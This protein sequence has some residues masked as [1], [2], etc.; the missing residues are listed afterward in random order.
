MSKSLNS[1]STPL[2]PYANTQSSR[3]FLYVV[4]CT[5]SLTAIN[6]G[7]VI[8]NINV[9][10]N[11]FN[12]CKEFLP[13]N[14]SPSGLQGCFL[15][16]TSWWGL[17][18]AGVP[19]GG[20][21][22]S[23][24]GG[25]IVRSFGLKRTILLMNIPMTLGFLLM[26]FASNLGMLV[27]GRMLQ[28]FVCGLSGVAVP[29]YISAVTPAKLSGIFINFFQLFL[30]F[31]ILV[32]EVFSYSADLGRY[33]WRWRYGFGAGLIVCASQV[34]SAVL[35]N[36]PETPNELERRD[37]MQKASALRQRLGFEASEAANLKDSAS[38][39]HVPKPDLAETDTF[40]DSLW[41]LL[42]FKISKANKSMALGLLLHAGQQICGVNA[43]FFYSSLIFAGGKEQNSSFNDPPTLNPISLAAVNVIMTF[44]AIWLLNRSGRR[45]VVLVSAAA[46]FGVFDSL[47]GLH[48]ESSQTL[49][50]SPSRLCSLLLCGIRTSSVDDDAGN[51]SSQM[52]AY[53]GR[54][55]NL[56]QCKLD[57][58]H[59][60]YWCFPLRCSPAQ[61]S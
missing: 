27:V 20:W 47:G 35:G 5:A 56:C 34:V 18:G 7:Y 16:S 29:S 19:L 57:R 55:F 41:N 10:G 15:V 31:G 58:Q 1:S 17:V 42:R 8:A 3:L 26:A 6:F 38:D 51:L 59:P 46:S 52:A 49:G 30:V 9:A 54:H 36:L 11:V 4:V 12:N 43:V 14:S 44:V 13:K 37:L 53:H 22:G 25:A 28:G 24:T 32:A 45:P 33:L 61:R 40:T 60:G 2:A 23:L 48:D 21:I 50:I 39:S